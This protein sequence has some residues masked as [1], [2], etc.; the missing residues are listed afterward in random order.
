MDIYHLG[1]LMRIEKWV[2]C[3][4]LFTKTYVLW[5]QKHR[6]KIE[7][8]GASTPTSFWGVLFVWIPVEDGAL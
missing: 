8:K 2:L 6:E 4:S 7:R 5:E 1:V 3:T